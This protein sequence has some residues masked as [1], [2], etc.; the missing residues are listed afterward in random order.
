MKTKEQAAREYVSE[1]SLSAS[2]KE[3][4]ID[5][6]KAGIEYAGRA[7]VVSYAEMMKS[8]EEQV[9]I[10]YALRE[11]TFYLINRIKGKETLMLKNDELSLILDLIDT[12]CKNCSH[13]KIKLNENYDENIFVKGEYDYIYSEG[14]KCFGITDGGAFLEMDKIKSKG[15]PYEVINCKDKL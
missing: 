13:P 4:G 15:I 10:K 5:C 6:F 2:E 11:L 9:N 3:I 14:W 7:C 12:L 1:G 8:I